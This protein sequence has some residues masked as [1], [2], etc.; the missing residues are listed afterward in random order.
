MKLPAR[1]LLL[2]A[3]ATVAYGQPESIDAEFAGAGARAMAMGGA[4]IGLADDATAGEF[5]PAG[6]RMLLRP[7]VSAQLAYTW[8]RRR[9]LGRA[10]T[11]NHL[12]PV[13]YDARD[14]YYTPSF[15]SVVWPLRRATVAV[16]QLANVRFARAW[17]D[18]EPFD[19]TNVRPALD[20]A[21]WNNVYGFSAAVDV[22]ERL[23]LGASLRMAHFRYAFRSHWRDGKLEDWS[24]AANVGVLYHWPRLSL[25]AVYKTPQ[26]VSGN[27]AGAPVSA[28]LP[29]TVGAG[30]AWKPDDRWRLLLD[31]DYI[32]WSSFD[33]QPDDW[34]RKDA[35]RFHAG[36]EWLAGWW[37]DTAVFLRAGAMVEE[38]NAFVYQGPPSGDLAGRLYHEPF[39]RAENIAHL[40]CGVGMARDRCQ[41]DVAVDVADN[42]S[43]DFIVSCI[44]YF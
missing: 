12:R 7:E 41:L 2:L 23:Y 10:S 1:A 20:R 17:E 8:D 38:S 36:G 18:P 16:N 26:R 31:A 11:L 4:F 44:L 6:L 40:A 15:F 43:V 27:L 37:G 29:Y 13:F 22:T 30:L 21:A 32:G 35:W 39:R 9:E 3:W 42:E 19:G 28:R 5:N 25:G 14:E 33:F 34:G 24:P